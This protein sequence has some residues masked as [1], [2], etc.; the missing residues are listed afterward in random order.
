VDGLIDTA[1]KGIKCKKAMMGK[2]EKVCEDGG[3]RNA[4]GKI[5]T[6]EEGGW[7]VGRGLGKRGEAGL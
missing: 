3:G 7:R 2:A 6:E 5:L 1:E 4:R